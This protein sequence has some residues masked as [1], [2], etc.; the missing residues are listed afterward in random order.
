MGSIR[1][2]ID[3]LIGHTD[4]L[5]KEKQEDH[6]SFVTITGSVYPIL[7]F[8]SNTAKEIQTRFQKDVA[9]LLSMPSIFIQPLSERIS[10]MLENFT[11]FTFTDGSDV[12]E[13][14]C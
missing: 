2:I 1:A 5:V 13:N 6:F 12:N 7:T 14:E 4:L 8:D 9:A 11:R 3:F 10:K